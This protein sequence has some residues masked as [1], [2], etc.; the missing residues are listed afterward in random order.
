MYAIRKNIYIIGT[1]RDSTDTNI[2]FKFVPSYNIVKSYLNN[3]ST[4][5][6]TIQSV[7]GRF[8]KRNNQ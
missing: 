3:T 7:S 5:V 4:V 2:L 1:L 6:Q 8:E